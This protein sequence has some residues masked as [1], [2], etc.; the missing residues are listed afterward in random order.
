MATYTKNV[1]M[2]SYIV[3]VVAVCLQCRVILYGTCIML[4]VL[5]PVRRD[6]DC[7]RNARWSMPTY[8]SKELS[9]S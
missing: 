5:H 6:F 8:S 3:H 9:L 7:A 1:Y 2:K 4:V